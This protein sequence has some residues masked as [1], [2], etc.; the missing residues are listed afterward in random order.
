MISVNNLTIRFGNFDLFNNVGFMINPRDRIGLVG[1]NGAGKTTLMKVIAGLYPP[2]EGV[3]QVPPGVHTGYLAQQFHNL[4]NDWT[5]LEETREAFAE[6]REVEKQLNDLN[7]AI[8][9]REDYESNEYHQLLNNLADAN[10]RFQFLGGEKVEANMV[11]TLKGLGFSETDMN[12]NISEFSGGWSMRLELAKLLLKQPEVLLLD[13]PTNHLDIISIQWLE[14][15]L[16]QYPGAVVCISHDRAFLDNITER[17]LEISVGKIYDYKVAYSQ[18]V[19]LRKERIT[20]QLSAYENQQKLIVE[21]ERF[22]E[23]FRY[24]ATKA[25]QVQSRV[26][27]LEKLDKIEIDEVDLRTL[28]FRFPEAPRSGS[29]VAEITEMSKSFGDLE[30]LRDVDFVLERGEKIALVGKNGEGKTTFSRILMG[31]LEYA[32]E[33]KIGGKV[34]I[35]YFAQNQDGLLDENSSVFDTL[36]SVAVGNVR[37]QIRSILGAFMFSGEDID[38]KVKVLSGGERSRLSLAKLMLEPYN[39]LILDEPTN[40]L[41]IQSKD[42][43]KEALQNYNGTLVIVSHDRYFLDGLVDKV[44][45]VINHKVKEEIGGINAYLKRYYDMIV[46]SLGGDKQGGFANKKQKQ[47]KQ[48]YKV[49]KEFDKKLRKLQ[50]KGEVCEH[51]ILEFESKIGKMNLEMQ[52]PDLLTPAF[53]EEYKLYKNKL[54]EAI[55]LWEDLAQKLDALEKERPFYE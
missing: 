31:E 19:F 29:V 16:K 46:K 8:A 13:E 23:R 17:T 33:V 18:F 5:V 37:T 26:K 52:N 38:K 42:V 1:K 36:D 41:D 3:V 51:E 24:K 10:E 28:N 14:V 21:T 6:I 34:S 44:Y 40:H 54:S 7:I 49:R 12:R 48:E 50:R 15:F 30:V 45:E 43:L 39:L 55:N 25:N 53:Y 27:A 20:Q 2:S 32:G 4:E 11:R 9:E 47:G 35:G 22:I